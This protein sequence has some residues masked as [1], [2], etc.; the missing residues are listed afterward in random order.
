MP[1]TPRKVRVTFHSQHLVDGQPVRMQAIAHTPSRVYHAHC[2]QADGVWV[3]EV[4]GAGIIFEGD[5][6]EQLKQSFEQAVLA[7]AG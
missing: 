1:P 5:T 7:H 3:G 2:Q 4:P 6:Q